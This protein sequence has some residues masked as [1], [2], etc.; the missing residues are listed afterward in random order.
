MCPALLFRALDLRNVNV[1]S[2]IA[3]EF[4]RSRVSR[5]PAFKHPAVFVIRSPEAILDSERLSGMER[6]QETIEAPLHIVSMHA[7][8]PSCAYFLLQ[9]SAGKVEPRLVEIVAKRIR[10]RHPNQHRRRVGH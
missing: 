10:S 8:G 5:N 7:L 2:D 6:R 1:R 9:G 4:S 3:R